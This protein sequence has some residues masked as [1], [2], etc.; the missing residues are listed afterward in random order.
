MEKLLRE[1]GENGLLKV[2][3]KCI[4]WPKNISNLTFGQKLLEQ[5]EK[6]GPC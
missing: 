1:V 4:F 2:L 3:S 6:V 5:L